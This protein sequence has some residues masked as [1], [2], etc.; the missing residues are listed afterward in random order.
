[1]G[2]TGRRGARMREKKKVAA[3]GVGAEK[4]A[5]AEIVEKANLEKEGGD[6]IEGGR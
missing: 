6:N 1:M 4:V 5:A 2:P 3:G